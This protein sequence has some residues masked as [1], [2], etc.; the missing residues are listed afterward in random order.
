MTKPPPLKA[1]FFD[2]DDTLFS[3]TEFVA[4]ARRC[5]I[6]TM[7]KKGLDAD[8]DKVLDEL[9]AVVEEFGS[10]DSRHYDRLL[11]RLPQKALAGKN[12]TLLVMAGVLAYHDTKWKKLKL[13]EAARDLLSVLSKF[14][15]RLGVITAGLKAKQMEKILRL[16][17]DRWVDQ[18]LIFITDQLGMEKTNPN[19]YKYA[20]DVAG[21]SPTSCLHVGDH[22]FR[23]IDT[24]KETGFQAIWHRGSGK[25]SSLN[26]R[27]NPDFICDSLS[28]LKAILEKNYL[29]EID[30]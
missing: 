19:L 18:D 20:S 8:V 30:Q 13:L 4:L 15:L 10:N 17:L 24:A 28:E 22:P 14:N 11:Q 16:G 25:Y 7:C 26:P 1:I 12:P 23:D 9:E 2:V 27:S 3:T 21:F 5:A 29:S 6:E